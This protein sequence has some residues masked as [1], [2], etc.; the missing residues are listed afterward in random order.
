MSTN[1]NRD[2]PGGPKSGWLN[3]TKE[4]QVLLESRLVSFLSRDSDPGYE[5]W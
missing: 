1:Q 4:T 3:L 5:F 2:H